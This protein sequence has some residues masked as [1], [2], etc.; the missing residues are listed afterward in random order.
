[1][2]FKRRTVVKKKFLALIFA[3]L[4]VVSSIPMVHAA[5]GNA[6]PKVSADGVVLNKSAE[7]KAD[8]TVD[9]TIEAYTK[10][11]VTQTSTVSPTDIILVLDVSGSM[12]DAFGSTAVVTYTPVLGERRE[13][14]TLIG[15][16]IDWLYGLHGNRTYYIEDPGNPGQYVAVV[17]DESQV[18]TRRPT[19]VTYT[20]EGYDDNLYSC[21]VIAG[22]TSGKR[23][24][25]QMSSEYSLITPALSNSEVVQF[26]TSTSSTPTRMDEMQRAVNTFIDQ[27]VASSA[28]ASAPH[29]ISVVKFA[30]PLYKTQRGTTSTITN[31]AQSVVGDDFSDGANCT[32][33]VFGLTDA[34]AAN[35]TT[36]KTAFSSLSEGGATSVDYG[37]ALAEH[38]LESRTQHAGRQAVVIVFTDGTPT[39]N[40]GFQLG[41][42]NSAVAYAEEIKD[43]GYPIYT[44]S[45]YPGA[46]PGLDPLSNYGNTGKTY[47]QYYNDLTGNL[48]NNSGFIDEASDIFMHAISSNYPDVK[49]DTT[50][51]YDITLGDRASGSDYYKSATDAASLQN[52]FSGIMSTIGH[53]TVQLGATAAVHDTIAPHFDISGIGGTPQITL[54]VVPKAEGGWD[55]WDTANTVVNPAGVNFVVNGR[56]LEITGFDFDA[57]YA[58]TTVRPSDLDDFNKNG[59]GAKLVVTIN[60]TPDYAE[61]DKLGDAASVL[62]TNADT[63]T[64]DGLYIKDSTGK[65]IVSAASPS[66]VPNKV[67]YTVDGNTVA[68][69]YRFAGATGL[70]VDALPTREG[71]TFTGWTTTDVTV[72]AGAFD[73]PSHDVVFAGSFTRNSYNVIY[74]YFNT[75]PDNVT[76]GTT[77]DPTYGEIVGKVSVPFGETYTYPETAFASPS[78]YDDDNTQYDFSGWEA[79]HPEL[80]V[81]NNSFV[82]PDHDVYIQGEFIK[83][84]DQKAYYKIYHHREDPNVSGGYITTESALHEDVVGERIKI[85]YNT[86]HGYS[87]DTAN[88]DTVNDVTLLAAHTDSAPAEIHLYYKLDALYTVTYAYDG[89]IPALIQTEVTAQL[90]ALNNAAAGP[91]GIGKNI[92]VGDA[93][94]VAGYTFTGW[95]SDGT[96]YAPGSTLTMPGHNV[97]LKGTLT[98][99]TNAQYTVRYYQQDLYGTGYTQVNRNGEP[100]NIGDVYTN[101]TVG[102][103][104]HAPVTTFTGFTLNLASSEMSGYVA[105]DDSLE[106][107]LYFDRN[108]YEV[109]YHYLSDSMLTTPTLPAT[110]TYKYGQTVTIADKLNESGYTFHGWLVGDVSA[111]AEITI[112]GNQF[113]MPAGDVKF[114]G[115]FAQ[116]FYVT[117]WL[118]DTTTGETREFAGPFEVPAGTVVVVGQDITTPANF[119][120]WTEVHPA[121]HTSQT[122][123]AVA[124]GQF[125]MPTED[126]H[127]YGEVANPTVTYYLR[128][129]PNGQYV[130]N[131]DPV[132]VFPGDFY[133]LREVIGTIP[134]GWSF[135]GWSSAVKADDDTVPV[136]IGGSGTSQSLVMPAYNVNVYG[137]LTNSA[138]T[139][140]YFV[141]G[142]QYGEPVSAR[143][144]ETY[145][146][147][148]G[149]T[150]YQA[151]AGKTFSGWTRAVQQSDP[152]S[153]LTITDSSILLPAYNVNI[154]GT[155]TD[156]GQYTV[157]Y[158]VNNE[159]YGTPI[160]VQAGTTH[161]L[162]AG[163]SVNWPSTFTGWETAYTAAGTPVSLQTGSFVMPESNVSVY[164]SVNVDSIPV[165]GNLVIEKKV[166]APADFPA[167]K[168][169]TFYVYYGSSNTP[170]RTVTVKANEPYSIWTTQ[171]GTY[172]VVEDVAAAQTEGYTLTAA[173]A[174]TTT[175]RFLQSAELT[176][177]NTYTAQPQLEKGDH[178]AY[179]IGYPD[180]TVR[181]DASITRAEAVT[182]FF[183]LMTD[184]SRAQF[185][186]QTNSY[187]D[188]ASDAWYNNA[189]STLTNAGVLE[190]YEDGTFRPDAE[191]T[192]AELVKIASAFFRTMPDPEDGF[193]D[194]DDHWAKTFIE[195]AKELGIVTGYENGAFLPDQSI[196]RAETMR[197]VNGTLERK[198]HK[199]YLLNDMIVW[200]DNP[201]D[202]WYYADVQE[203][204][205]SHTY[206][207]V[208]DHEVWQTLTPNRD[209]AALE[210]VWSE[211][212]VTP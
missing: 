71:H 87:A 16:H 61:I 97:I 53:P 107:E 14:T 128:Q 187:P 196:T 78:G 33:V 186:S 140:T 166:V 54:R 180:G 10:G 48:S 40:N 51:A 81:T 57:Y 79:A 62:K 17:P 60:V 139:V 143:S 119:T 94:N 184:A 5:D 204:T 24:Y 169:F 35:Q 200:P 63:D 145:T 172:T 116:H 126:V 121:D 191:I 66:L 133:S 6:L 197:I 175:V 203:A 19:V 29:R 167:D 111:G 9:I 142:V 157:T 179:I 118:K 70:S 193:A 46:E 84:A 38:V 59:C 49:A 2:K 47:I 210:R 148:T 120:A 177:T 55:S 22:D 73:M 34:T 103:Y 206:E 105:A 37:L 28:T 110:V 132:S 41:V 92:T 99:L 108:T 44:V 152:E 30:S 160:T 23:Y 76:P 75:I 31:V 85:P 155:T 199:D 146:L 211:T 202:A 130:A 209:W 115:G 102:A 125:T 113:T 114:Y 43:G 144:G 190:G 159:P 164:G 25:P 12:D 201:V 50:T 39:H 176:F 7:L 181:P 136:T 26:Y 42:A 86:Y 69:Y 195:A 109:S 18:Q 154:Y 123:I 122:T 80:S 93:L 183:R 95:T 161:T 58:T 90:A 198:P 96:P 150:P 82:M 174:Q 3:V 45:V 112:T 208:S 20:E 158:Y 100:S 131:G 178:F 56:D 8:G 21:F 11:Q 165:M 27:A 88:P 106:L 137:E 138:I 101:Q 67:I 89:E 127:I 141:D 124:G 77:V 185:W 194:T 13:W 65:V 83:D 212:Y 207:T 147:G 32:Q 74:R 205:N 173:A 170:T 156:R 163:P 192:R 135:N 188:V 168:T 104:V 1:M 91:Y 129:G 98:P 149:I 36:M 162:I 15:G 64:A 4:L 134:A 151:P 153:D 182:I 72:T 117:Y 189:I 171:L 68:T 52:I